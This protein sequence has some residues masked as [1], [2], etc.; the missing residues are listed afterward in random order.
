MPESQ[1]DAETWYVFYSE[2]ENREYYFEPTSKQ[3]S[4]TLPQGARLHPFDDSEDAETSEG[5][6]PRESAPG[7][8]GFSD[9]DD[10]MLLDEA[11]AFPNYAAILGF[12][13]NLFSSP[14]FG[15][16]MLVLNVLLASRW[17]GHSAGPTGNSTSLVVLPA[18]VMESCPP[19][20]N[21]VTYIEVFVPQKTE[22]VI[23]PKQEVTMYHNLFT[24]KPKETDMVKEAV[25]TATRRTKSILQRIEE[26]VAIDTRGSQSIATTAAAK[27][28]DQAEKACRMPLSRVFNPRCRE[29][30]VPK[31]DETETVADV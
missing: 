12:F 25:E 8:S 23:V 2:K 26:T 20:V 30:F 9:D 3:A 5:F 21:N 1:Q 27:E 31:S 18:P 28:E 16:A 29:S 15:V 13:V 11:S 14:R 10:D 24:R 4:W 6:S 17:V 19:V 22:D 7:F